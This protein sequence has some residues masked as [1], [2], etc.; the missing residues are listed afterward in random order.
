MFWIGIIL[1]LIGSYVCGLGMGGN[2][3]KKDYVLVFG[4]VFFWIPG[5]V[6][7]FMSGGI[8]WGVLYLFV[9]A[10]LTTTFA[11]S[12]ARKYGARR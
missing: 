8:L 2:G 7:T 9:A 6:L 3:T 12:F 4:A 5:A 1:G 11:D 10:G